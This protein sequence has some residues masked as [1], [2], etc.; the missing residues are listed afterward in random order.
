MLT[1]MNWSGSRVLVTGASGVISTVLVRLLIDAGAEVLP[2]NGLNFY[3]EF[4]CFQN[5]LE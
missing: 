3:S 1:R 5:A 2:T 4:S